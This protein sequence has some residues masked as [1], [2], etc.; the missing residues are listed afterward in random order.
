[1]FRTL[2]Q[3]TVLFAVPAITLLWINS[4]GDELSGA[5]VNGICFSTNNRAGE[6]ALLEAIPSLTVVATYALIAA[7]SPIVLFLLSAAICGASRRL[8]AAIFP[9]LV[10]TALF[11]AAVNLLIQGAL[12]LMDLYA[13]FAY[14]TGFS[15][16]FALRVAAAALMLGVFLTIM[17]TVFTQVERPY[18]VRAA[19]VTPRRARGLLSEIARL[20]DQLGIAPPS[21]VIVGLEPMS[22]AIACPVQLSGY[23]QTG[24]L[25]GMTLHVS[26]TQLRALGDKGVTALIASELA[27]FRARDRSWSTRFQPLWCGLSGRYRRLGAEKH[28]DDRTRSLFGPLVNAAGMPVRATLGLLATCFSANVRRIIRRRYAQGDR[29]AAG[30]VGP[31]ALGRALSQAAAIQDAWEDVLSIHVERAKARGRLCGNLAGAFSDMAALGLERRRVRSLARTRLR[32]PT[33]RG[34]ILGARLARL[35]IDSHTINEAAT[36][37]APAEESRLVTGQQDL[38]FELTSAENRSLQ[39]SEQIPASGL[40]SSDTPADPETLSLLGLAAVL[41]GIGSVPKLRFDA[42]LEAQRHETIEIDPFDLA[43]AVSGRLPVPEAGDAIRRL[44]RL[45]A[46][47]DRHWIVRWLGDIAGADGGPSDDERELIEHIR[48]LLLQERAKPL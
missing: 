34:P 27:H 33:D 9:I 10:P 1:M 15:S 44:E 23:G 17:S 45:S 37:I 13:A 40:A 22:W 41:I 36:S 6:C 4:A 18:P 32:H 20:S 43:A 25:E 30:I 3:F 42:A 2:G 47:E 19:L 14:A 29:A 28:N 7:A 26:L 31:D 38:E 39:D 8:N 48:R 24:R 35:G 46:L 5:R 12:L 21:Q 16:L 11:F